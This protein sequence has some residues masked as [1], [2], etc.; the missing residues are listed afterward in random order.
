VEEGLFLDGVAL[1]G[2]DRPANEAGEA[3]RPVFPDAADATAAGFDPAAVGAEGA[4][5]RVFTF[6]FVEKRFTGHF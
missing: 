5:D 4:S 3:P 2:N 1:C 6:L